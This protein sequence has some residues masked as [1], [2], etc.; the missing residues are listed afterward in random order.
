VTISISFR[1]ASQ[2]NIP[3]FMLSPDFELATNRLSMTPSFVV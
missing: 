2:P 1:I 3:I